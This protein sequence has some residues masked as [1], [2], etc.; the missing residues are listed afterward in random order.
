MEFLTYS[1][2][3]YRPDMA[4]MQDKIGFSIMDDM[5]IARS[6]MVDCQIRTNGVI[7]NKVLDAFEA[8]PREKF[9]PAN[10]AAVAYT[11]KPLD[12]GSG[13]YL[14]DPMTHA[15]MVQAL[16]LK[17]S[18]VLLDVGTGCGYAAAIASGLVT[19][20]LSLGT[21][22]A[23]QDKVDTTLNGVDIH[24]VVFVKG[25]LVQGLPDQA[26]F[27]AVFLSGAVAQMPDNLLDQL[28]LGGR[29]VAVVRP[30]EKSVGQVT[31]FVK[32]E[33][34]HVS[35]RVLFE[36]SLPYLAGFEPKEAFVF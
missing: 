17:P 22:Q 36:S 26:P 35:S 5:Q 16:A 30:D 31:L 29:A 8:V 28:G 12:L 27:D 32:D 20:V 4:A 21:R 34:G 9:V 3:N 14:M 23:E 24:N 13:R 1:N 10:K 7:D 2:Q 15:R 19:T 18:D 11:D 25:K 33:T 6:H